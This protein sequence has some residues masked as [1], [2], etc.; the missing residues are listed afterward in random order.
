MKTASKD[1]EPNQIRL[2]TRRERQVYRLL[3]MAQANKEIASSLG[4]AER[5][6]RFHVSNVLHK[7]GLSGRI[8]ILAKNWPESQ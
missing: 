4:I 2:L 8:E 3:Q 1:N 7:L 6:A 5:T